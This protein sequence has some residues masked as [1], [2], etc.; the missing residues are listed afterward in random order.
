[1]GTLKAKPKKKQLQT[2]KT[3][4]FVVRIIKVI[5]VMIKEPVKK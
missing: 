3:K 5:E 1:M 4:K 2:K